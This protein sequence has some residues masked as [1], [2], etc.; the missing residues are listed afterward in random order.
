[1]PMPVRLAVLV[2]ILMAKI[3]NTMPVA[4][5]IRYSLAWEGIGM[6]MVTTT[7]ADHVK[8]HGRKR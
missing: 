4:I 2:V 7:P 1:M 6:H 8:Q 5:A 3:L